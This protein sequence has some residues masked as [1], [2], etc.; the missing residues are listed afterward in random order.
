MMKMRP[1]TDFNLRDP[2]RAPVSST[3]TN[4]DE[5]DEPGMMSIRVCL[6]DRSPDRNG[7]TRDRGLI[8]EGGDGVDE[9]CAIAFSKGCL[10]DASWE[11]V[12]DGIIWNYGG[13]PNCFSERLCYS[14]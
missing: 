1:P 2:R 14:G 8:R 10:S 5:T 9:D 6:I 12:R 7:R 4:P 11:S 3:G 13:W